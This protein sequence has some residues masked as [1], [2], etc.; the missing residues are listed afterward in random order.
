MT[1][2]RSLV[3]S[4]SDISSQ[5]RQK[6]SRSANARLKSRNLETKLGSGPKEVSA[7]QGGE[8][9][10]LTGDSAKATA[11]TPQTANPLWYDQGPLD[12]IALRS[13]SRKASSA[14]FVTLGSRPD[15]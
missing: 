5:I 8:P 4:V 15:Y 7:G 14:L 1:S 13:M 3:P 11:K 6:F 2:F 9:S 10:D 12:R